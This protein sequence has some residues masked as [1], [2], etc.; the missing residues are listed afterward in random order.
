M[1]W[2]AAREFAG[3]IDRLDLDR[4]RRPD[5]LGPGELVKDNRIRTVARAPDP[6]RPGGPGLIV[7]RYKFGRPVDRLK[8]LL[9]HTQA[10]T[11]WKVSRAL[12]A[13]GIPACEVLAIAVRRR[14]CVPREAFLVSREIADAVPLKTFLRDGLGEAERADPGFR[15]A[16]IEEAADLTARL[17]GA[18]FRH[19]DYHAENLLVRPAAPAGERL[20]VVDLHRIRRGRVDQRTV[21]NMLGSLFSSAASPGIT[22]EGRLDFLR[23]FLPRW[24]G[25]PDVSEESVQSWLGRVEDAMRGLRRRRARSRTRRCLVESSLFTAQ[26]TGD[27]RVRRRRDFP[28]EAALSAVGLHEAAMAGGAAGVQVY[29]QGRRTEVTTCPSGSVPPR[30]LNRPAP[31]GRVGSGRVCV[32]SFRRPS[33]PE[34]LKDCLRPRSRARAAWVAARGF[35][36]RGVPAAQPLALLESRHRLSGRPDYLVTE[37]LEND[38]TLPELLAGP[39]LDA[40]DRR[41]LGRAIADLF[42]T[43]AEREVYHPDTKPTNI[44]VRRAEGGFLLWLVD[45]DRVRFDAPMG[46]ERWAK[47]L[48]RV[49]ADLP[50][51]IG[52][53]DRMRCLRQCGRGRWSAGERRRLA[54]R[55]AALSIKRRRK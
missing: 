1:R 55:V 3:T 23:A 24:R 37:C 10:R 35:H 51:A 14:R 33:L 8:G 42:N 16:L 7:K 25:T 2:L 11:E 48:T 22:H 43:L 21:L 40:R 49:N 47:C 29:R 41:A 32:K 27:Y 18:G 5:A 20:F 4:L 39:S 28:L 38:G 54:R 31:P 13:A 50:D 15:R 19:H 30:T 44:L 36:V 6:D 52:L 9:G 45:L 17:V 46:Q 34:R 53:L 12:R 26:A